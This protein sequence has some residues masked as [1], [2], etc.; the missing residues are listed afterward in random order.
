MV[1]CKHKR[2]DTAL[3]ICYA[4]SNTPYGC[5]DTPY[6]NGDAAQW[7]GERDFAHGLHLAKARLIEGHRKDQYVWLDINHWLYADPKLRQE[8]GSE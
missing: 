2:K 6:V 8:R 3:Q 5:V 1:D 4:V 7:T